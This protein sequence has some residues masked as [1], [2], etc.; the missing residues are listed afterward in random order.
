MVWCKACSRDKADEAFAGGF[1]TCSAC[2][3][4]DSRR[5]DRLAQEPVEEGHRRCQSCRTCKPFAEFNGFNK[6]C[7]T[8][9]ALK[10]ERRARLKSQD[11]D[12]HAERIKQGPMG[13]E[14]GLLWQDA[15]YWPFG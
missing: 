9:V 14:L 11:A 1:K 4:M 6:N 13:Q 10:S 12:A 3:E 15:N 8:C 5:R 2:R 7:K